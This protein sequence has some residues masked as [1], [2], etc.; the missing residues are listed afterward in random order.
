[1]GF[2][3]QDIVKN[4][5]QIRTQVSDIGATRIRTRSPRKTKQRNARSSRMDVD[6]DADDEGDGSDDEKDAYKNNRLKVQSV[7][8]V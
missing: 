3:R 2:C 5:D 8:H 1:M 7:Y 4:I 6:G